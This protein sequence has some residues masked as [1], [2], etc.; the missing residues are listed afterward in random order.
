MD[1]VKSPIV[2][3][4]AVRVPLGHGLQLIPVPESDAAPALIVV[5][6]EEEVRFLV[7]D[8]LVVGQAAP[9]GDALRDICLERALGLYSGRRPS[10]RSHRCKGA[11][12]WPRRTALPGGADPWSCSSHSGTSHRIHEIIVHN[13]EAD[14]VAGADADAK[15]IRPSDLS[16]IMPPVRHAQQWP[17][18]TSM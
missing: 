14:V 18:I 13:V 12:R 5:L 1:E 17:S 6:A 11:G 9:D 4:A 10:C 16:A 8:G 15:Y 2:L 3:P 7:R